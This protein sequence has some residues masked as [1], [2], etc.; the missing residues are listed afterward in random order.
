[1]NVRRMT[2]LDL[3]G[4]RVLIR[5]DLNVPVEAGVITSEARIRAALPTLQAARAQGARVMVLSHLGRPKEGEF[6]AE[7]SLAPVATRLG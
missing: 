1:M 4:Q 2:D 6:S 3:R 7:N 5:E